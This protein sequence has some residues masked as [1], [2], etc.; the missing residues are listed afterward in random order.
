M[1]PIYLLIMDVARVGIAHII[2]ISG[3]TGVPQV[4]ASGLLLS[5]NRC[6]WE[7]RRPRR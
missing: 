2:G 6:P 7:P 1:G 4:A 5:G 3:Y